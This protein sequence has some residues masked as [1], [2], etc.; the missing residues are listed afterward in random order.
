DAAHLK[1][2]FEYARC[3]NLLDKKVKSLPE[4]RLTNS[5]PANTYLTYF[6]HFLKK[7]QD[8]FFGLHFGVFLN[9]RALH[10]LFDISLSVVNVK[11]LVMIWKHYAKA[12]FPLIDISVAE[13]P[14]TYSLIFNVPSEVASA[15][16]LADA[17]IALAFREL[18]IITGIDTLSITLP[19]NTL[20][21]Y[22]QWFEGLVNRG[23]HYAITFHRP[24][25][26]I[27]TNN[28]LRKRIELLLPTF[29]HYL[30]SLEVEDQ[31]FSHKVKLMILNLYESDFPKV[32]KVASQFCL[33]TRTLQR[34]LRQEHTTYRVI[35]NQVK[36]ELY[37]Y[38][39]KDRQLKTVDVS[40]ILGY[41]SASAF[42]HA[43]KS[44]HTV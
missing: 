40:S 20:T 5:V 4:I 26:K 2:L 35:T 13:K 30:N 33:T 39:E 37:A 21:E 43:L 3:R 17:I 36:Q 8:P 16:Q 19:Y 31:S 23:K 42:L 12:S 22:E 41:S 6:N 29:L 15:S 25:N 24:V 14:S 38:I 10:I 7:S 34:K 44:W 27:V 9:L 32:A 1:N 11:Q 28:I 18:R